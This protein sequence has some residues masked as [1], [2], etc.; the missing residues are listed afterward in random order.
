MHQKK[1][2][3]FALR[4]LVLT[5]SLLLLC[6]I[7]AVGITWA[8]YRAEEDSFL[9]YTTRDPGAVS[10]WAGYNELTGTLT[11]GEIPWTFSN[12]TG[13]AQFYISN[14]TSEAD[15]SDEDLSAAIR[16]LVSLNAADAQVELSVSDGSSTATWGGTPVE[17]QEGTPLF[18]SF[19]GGTAYVFQNENGSELDWNLEGGALSVLSVQI[20]VSNLEQ[21]DGAALLQVQVVGK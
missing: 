2:R 20:E 15:Y 5:V 19:G 18:T 16:L 14:G 1:N 3:P 12:G 17:I 6:I 21:L 4:R 10:L 13:T 8:R 7:L 11:A 9:Q